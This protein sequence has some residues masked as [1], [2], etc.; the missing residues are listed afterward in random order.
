MS[1]P[2]PSWRCQK[3]SS[4]ALHYAEVISS[5][6]GERKKTDGGSLRDDVLVAVLSH[7]ELEEV[8]VETDAIAEGLEDR[9]KDGD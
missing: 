3:V 8:I 7:W 6:S 9:R 2:L 1:S 4:R 5:N